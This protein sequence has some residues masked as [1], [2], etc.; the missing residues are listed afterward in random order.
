[1]R[2]LEYMSRYEVIV[3]SWGYMLQCGVIV[4]SWGYMLGYEVIVGLWGY[5]KVRGHCG[6]DEDVCQGMR[7]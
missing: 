5:V 7:S 6:G 1:M 3:G 2:S 4:G